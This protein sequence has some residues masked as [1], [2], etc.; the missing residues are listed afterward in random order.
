MSAGQPSGRP[1]GRR[2]D[3]LRPVELL[4]DYAPYAEGSTLITMGDTHVLCTATVEDT[5][6]PFLIG[7]DQG[8]IT[9]EYGMLPR[10]SPQRIPRSLSSGRTKEIQRLIGRSLRAA[11]DLAAV[12]ERTVLIDCDVL[13]ADGGTRTAAITGSYVALHR[14]LEKLVASGELDRLPELTAVAAISAGIVSGRPL[15]DL[16]YVEDAAATVDLNVVMTERGELVEVQGTAEESSFPRSALNE[17]LDLCELGI[18]QLV[19]L[20]QRALGVR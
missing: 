2:D 1:G 11:V 19:D 8:W 10:S 7:R 16:E 18:G 14:A 5:V 15:L 13:R 6:P 12:G 20:Q 9:A 4:L 17:L 3:E